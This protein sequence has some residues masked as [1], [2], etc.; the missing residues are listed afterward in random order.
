MH[1]DYYEKYLKMGLKP[2]DFASNINPFRPR[3]L[4]E[5]LI[6]A[7]ESA[8]YYPQNSYRSLIEVISGSTGW[9]SENVVFGNG[10]IELIEFFFRMLR[11]DVAIV[12]PTFTEYERFARIYGLRVYNVPWS[13]ERILEFI[14]GRSPEGIVICNP[15]NPTGEFF[16][17]AVM[18]EISETCQ[19]RN[20]KLMV[21]QAFIDFVKPHDVDAFQIRSLTKILGIPGLRFGYGC[22]PEEYARK[23]HDT[24]MPWS[25]NGV[26]KFVAEKYLPRL[27]TFSRH[28]RARIKTERRHLVRSL[29]KLGFE[30]RGKANFLLCEGGFH[31]EDIFK[32]LER[33]N[34]LIRTCSDFRWLTDS[35]FR[36]AVKK[37]DENRILLRELEVFVQENA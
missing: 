5:N 26:A 33:K 2:L 7:I 35:H 17:K 16:R 11:K 4:H 25:V 12:Q 15:N 29:R 22:F 10:S 13:V 30:C 8:Y 28:V 20:V 36:I 31:A 1:G 9:D 3:D 6:E 21:D 24:R 27:G 18:E 14:D 37:R 32:F 19:R 23:F 34:I